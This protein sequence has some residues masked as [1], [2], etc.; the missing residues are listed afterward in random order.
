MVRG[1]AVVVALDGRAVVDP[2]EPSAVVE[3]FVVG[4]SAVLPTEVA[5]AVVRGRRAH[6]GRLVG[7]VVR[8]RPWSAVAAGARGAGRAREAGVSNPGSRA[9]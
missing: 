5:V 9:V 1:R 4:S 3:R 7:A 8:R 2:V 6:R